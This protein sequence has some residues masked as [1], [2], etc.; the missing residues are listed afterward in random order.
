MNLSA[1]LNVFFK[2]NQQFFLDSRLI[3]SCF[4]E[5]YESGKRKYLKKIKNCKEIAKI[6]LLTGYRRDFQTYSD[7]LSWSD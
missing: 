7:N 5:K 2:K 3:N 6:K 1:N 4:Y